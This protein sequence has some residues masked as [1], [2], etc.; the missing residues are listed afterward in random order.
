VAAGRLGL[1]Y[2]WSFGDGTSASLTTTSTVHDYPKAG[3]YIL[4]LTATDN[5]G[6]SAAFSRRINPISLS[7]RGYKQNGQQKVDLSWNGAAGTSFDVY[8]DGTK[9][10]VVQATAY[11]DG[12]PKGSAGTYRV[13]ASADPICSNEATV[14]L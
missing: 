1:T 13:C 6:A 4:T 10:A 14:S 9:I 7:A 12:V 2:G 8:R 5:D 3:S 11:T